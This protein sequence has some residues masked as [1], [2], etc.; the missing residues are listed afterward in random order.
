MAPGGLVDSLP[1]GN[2]NKP[3]TVRDH[4]AANAWFYAPLPENKY[5]SQHFVLLWDVGKQM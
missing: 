4:G 3:E 1:P 5:F 2:H